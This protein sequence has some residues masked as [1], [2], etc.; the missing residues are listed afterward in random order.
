MICGMWSSRWS[1]YISVATG[2]YLLDQI[3]HATEDF[4]WIVWSEFCR[5]RLQWESS[6]RFCYM[7]TSGFIFPMGKYTTPSIISL[8]STR[9]ARIPTSFEYDRL[10]CRVSWYALASGCEWEST[11]ARTSY[12]RGK[13]RGGSMVIWWRRK[14]RNH[15]R[16][17]REWYTL[18]ISSYRKLRYH[19]HILLW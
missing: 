17:D 16:H 19:T 14:I 1:Q 7:R 10:E 2:D 6:S 18:P 12:Y 3:D 15:P 4:C 11:L 8:W 5:R 13:Y 9:K